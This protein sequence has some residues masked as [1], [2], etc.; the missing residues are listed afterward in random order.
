MK[1]RKNKFY[2]RKHG[3]VKRIKPIRI[4]LVFV[5]FAAGCATVLPPPPESSGPALAP[6]RYTIQVGAFANLDNASNLSDDLERNGLEAYYFADSDGL[7]KVRFG[8]FPSRPA[9]RR[10]AESLRAAGVID[11]FYIVGPG[12]FGPT[13]SEDALRQ[14]L[15]QTA[16]GYI[17]LPYRWGGAS[18]Q[19]GFD[20]SGLTMTVYRLNGLNLPR[21][22]RQQYRRGSPIER[23]RIQRGDLV[24][25]ATSGRGVV[26][27]VGIYAGGG[28]FIHAPKSGGTIRTDSI[29]NGY[30]SRR[31]VGARNYLR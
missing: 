19:D 17:G 27:H 12:D 28:R 21:S 9:A 3:W 5:L 22:S 18:P 13:L 26:S 10:Q 23:H 11:A 25:F 7:F 14:Q 31:Y 16:E 6:I 4:L 15:V 24:F 2:I 30:F 8:E 1:K 29:K 20:C